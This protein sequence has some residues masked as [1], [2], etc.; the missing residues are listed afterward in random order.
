MA[1]FAN[2]L[3]GFAKSF[4]IWMYNHGIG[5]FQ[6]A[7]DGFFT[8]A[9]TLV[10]LLPDGAAVPVHDIIPDA[11]M[12]DQLLNVIN[13]LFPVAYLITC[14]TWVVGGMVAYLAIAPVLRW[15][16]ILS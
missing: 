3:I 15:V 2:W 5:W 8:F 4:L 6:A 13:W 14:T 9:L 16:K 12:L 11:G 7:I 10:N 1:A